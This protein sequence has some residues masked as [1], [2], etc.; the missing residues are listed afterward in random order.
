M[1]RPSNGVATRIGADVR[2][3]RQGADCIGVYFAPLF[4]RWYSPAGDLP[5]L[6]GSVTGRAPEMFSRSFFAGVA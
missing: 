3:R 5:T 4:M 1:N 6:A 2:F